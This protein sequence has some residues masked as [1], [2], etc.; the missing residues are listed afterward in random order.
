M[1]LLC[2]NRHAS[3]AKCE[4]KNILRNINIKDNDISKFNHLCVGNKFLS[5]FFI[6]HSHISEL[7]NNLHVSENKHHCSAE[8]NWID[9][10]I[11]QKFQNHYIS[12][13]IKSFLP[14]LHLSENHAM[15]RSEGKHLNVA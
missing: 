7:T 6:Q 11:W 9:I 10:K 5:M 8:Y 15:E 3:K 4:K 14:G 1:Y 12:S 2:D 13:E